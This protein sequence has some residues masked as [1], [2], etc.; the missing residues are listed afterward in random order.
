M[1]THMQPFRHLHRSYDAPRPYPNAGGLI[2]FAGTWAGDDIH[3]VS[4]AV[5]HLESTET[6]WLPPRSL[7]EPWVCTCHRIQNGRLFSAHRSGL[8][9]TISG[10]SA[11]ELVLRIQTRL[12]LRGV[13]DPAIPARL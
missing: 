10:R 11:R 4:R 1:Q 12:R 9:E 5:E 8:N 13:A 6:H 7:G 3:I 2:H